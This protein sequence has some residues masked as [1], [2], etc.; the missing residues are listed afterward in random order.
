MSHRLPEYIDPWRIA[1][2]GGRLWGSLRLAGM[3]RLA[4]EILD[5]SGEVEVEVGSTVSAAPPVIEGC[6]CVTVS[7]TCQ[8][9]LEPVTV[10][11]DAAFRLGLVESDESAS[12]LADE[13]D[14]LIVRRN[15]TCSLA[16][17]VED[18]LILALPIVPR[19]A[20]GSGC[21]GDEFA[22]DEAIPAR[23][24]FSELG[25]LWAR[26]KEQEQ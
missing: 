20:E 11:L 2:G 10:P 1:E 25:A 22:T 24:P 8:R 4:S 7:M 19:H 6:A 9:C 3:Q 14:P 17:L 15:D 5:A 16:Q 18:E 23:R 26:S 21:G 13:L 12:E